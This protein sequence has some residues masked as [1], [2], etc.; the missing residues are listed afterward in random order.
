VW[1]GSFKDYIRCIVQEPVLVHP[2]ELVLHDAVFPVG[3]FVIGMLVF[4]IIVL[5]ELFFVGFVAH[6][7]LFFLKVIID[8]QT[9]IRKFLGGAFMN[10][11][12]FCRGRYLNKIN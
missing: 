12:F 8:V 2:S 1:N 3:G 4:G 10:R 11:V 6:G 5:E 9:K 7:V